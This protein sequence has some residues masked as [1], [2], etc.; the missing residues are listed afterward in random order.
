M[1]I[2]KTIKKAI[3]KVTPKKKEDKIT[4]VLSWDEFINEWQSKTREVID[5]VAHHPDAHYLGASTGQCPLC[6][7]T[8][9]SAKHI[10][11]NLQG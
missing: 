8:L 11:A 3:K 1:P 9:P 10:F 7:D 4:I 2:K 6:D 5:A